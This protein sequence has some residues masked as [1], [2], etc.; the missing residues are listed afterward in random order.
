VRADAV[1]GAPPGQVALTPD[2]DLGVVD[3]E[4]RGSELSSTVRRTSSTL[5]GVGRDL[6]PFGA[7]LLGH[8]LD[9]RRVGREHDAAAIGST[10]CA[11]ARRCARRRPGRPVAT[12]PR[13]VRADSAPTVASSA[14]SMRPAEHRGPL[15]VQ[16]RYRRS[17]ARWRRR[18][19]SVRALRRAGRPVAGRPARARRRRTVAPSTS[20]S[21]VRGSS[22]K[23]GIQPSMPSKS[24][25]VARRSN[26]ERPHGRVAISDSARRRVPRWGSTR[27]PP[28]WSPRRGRAANADWRCRRR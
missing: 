15:C 16:Q 11:R 10:R 9:G 26:V 27:A 4:A 6:E 18:R 3:A 1:H 19:R 5:V 21:N 25:P 7:Q 20:S 24:W 22:T 28:R 12:E 23:S 17:P 8:A 14:T 13:G 2:H